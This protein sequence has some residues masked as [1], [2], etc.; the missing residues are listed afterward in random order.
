MT[1][2]ERRNLALIL[3]AA[4]IALVLLTACGTTTHHALPPYEPPLAKTDFQHVHTTA[5]THTEADHRQYSNRNALG[6]EL[7]AAGP[8]IHRAEV[9]T[10]ATLAYEVQRAIPVNESGSYSPPLQPFSMEERRTVVARTAKRPPKPTRNVK[11]AVAVSKPPQ[12]GSAA[13]DWSRWPAGTVFRLLSTGQNYRV[14]D[15]GWA[16]SGRNTIDLYMANQR[17]MNSWGAREEAIEI[18]K[19]G[20]P[21]ESLQFLRRHQDYRHIKRMVLELE[22]R[23]NEAAS[24]R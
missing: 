11:R 2:A 3:L 21:Q 23:E 6:G 12:I 8:A 19:W 13:A 15:Y 16:L 5:Y 1:Y 20:D 24:L 4:F 17:E 10:R 9:V 14:E 18:L 22:G 7:R